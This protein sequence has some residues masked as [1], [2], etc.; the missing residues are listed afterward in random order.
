MQRAVT[1]EAEGR[2]AAV[3]PF[4]LFW[5]KYF[6]ITSFSGSGRVATLPPDLTVER[7]VIYNGE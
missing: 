6:G 7:L 3:I 4:H 2:F 1:E 5:R